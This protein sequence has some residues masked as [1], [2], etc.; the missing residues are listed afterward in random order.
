MKLKVLIAILVV[1]FVLYAVGL[2][3]GG[4]NRGG[5]EDDPPAWVSA[6]GR[7]KPKLSAQEVVSS[8]PA[9]CKSQFDGGRIVL[10]QGQAC[11]LTIAESSGRLFSA[12]VR[13]LLLRLTRG[14]SA[15]IKIDPKEPDRFD[16]EHSLPKPADET[17]P[18]IYREGGVVTIT[19]SVGT[20]GQ[21]WIEPQ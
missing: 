5:V 1:L 10:A 6:L 21:C 18:Q 12:S 8:V 9:S 16:I 20:D 14:V 15:S 11:A 13:T 19:C 4:C 2:G 3:M 7:R 17:D